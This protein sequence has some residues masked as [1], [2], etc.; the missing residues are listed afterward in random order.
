MSTSLPNT[1]SPG[2]VSRHGL[3]SD[4][5]GNLLAASDDSS[6]PL[7]VRLATEEVGRE[8]RCQSEDDERP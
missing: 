3:L 1:P 6:A 7:F 8:R 5:R 4:V 2:K